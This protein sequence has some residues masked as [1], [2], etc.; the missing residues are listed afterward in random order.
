[1][2]PPL[3][4]CPHLLCLSPPIMSVPTFYVC[5]HLL[6]L[7]PPTMSVPT[8]YICPHQSC[9]SPPIIL[10][11]DKPFLNLECL[12]NVRVCLECFSRVFGQG[13]EGSMVSLSLRKG[14]FTWLHLGSS[15]RLKI[16]QVP[17]CKMEPQS[18]IISCKNPIH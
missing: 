8:F 9:L 7:S 16:W 11:A 18:G 3:K 17:A 5:P 15:A 14:H 6:C 10:F 1:M 2:R 13:L 12:G 4:I